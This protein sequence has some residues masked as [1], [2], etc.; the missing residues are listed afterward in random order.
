MRKNALGYRAYSPQP[1]SLAEFLERGR[2]G[3]EKRKKIKQEGRGEKGE[4]RAEGGKGVL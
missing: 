3:K 1:D 4:S 2:S